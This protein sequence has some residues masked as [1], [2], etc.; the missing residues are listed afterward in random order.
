ML[1]LC[2]IRWLSGA[3]ENPTGVSS[4][5]SK[6]RFQSKDIKIDMRDLLVAQIMDNSFRCCFS[7]SRMARVKL[8]KNYVSRFYIGGSE[9]VDARWGTMMIIDIVHN[10]LLS[11]DC[12]RTIL[13]LISGC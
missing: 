7:L 6:S 10:E 12:R 11:F 8:D 5:F 13:S 3:V 4:T 1:N 9:G 2:C